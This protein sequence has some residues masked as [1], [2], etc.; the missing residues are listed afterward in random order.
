ML[1]EGSPCMVQPNVKAPFQYAI[2]RH[3]ILYDLVKTRC[4]AI[5]SLNY[6]IAMKFDRHV[7]IAAAEVPVKFRSDQTIV[8]TNLAA[9]QTRA[10]HKIPYTRTQ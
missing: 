1:E 4:R 7:S 3:V 6:C 10:L 5:D 8:N 9:L 2:R